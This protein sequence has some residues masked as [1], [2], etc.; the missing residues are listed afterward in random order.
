[1]AHTPHDLHD[2]F[3]EFA[4]K[5]TVLRRSDTHFAKMVDAYDEVNGRIHKAETNIEPVD[6]F[7]EET[8]RKLRMKLKD[9][10]YAKLLSS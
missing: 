7:T 3:P 1:M 10:I 8:F 4:S 2:E 5:I 6:N 9:E